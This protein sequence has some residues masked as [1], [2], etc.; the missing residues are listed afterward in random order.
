MNSNRPFLIVVAVL[1]ALGIGYEFSTR[2]TGYE[3]DLRLTKLDQFSVQLDGTLGSDSLGVLRRYIGSHP[4]T[5]NLI[6]G[7][8]PGTIDVD[9]TVSM[10]RWVRKRGL[11][12]S[13]TEDSAIASGAVDLFIG[14]AYRS[15][16]CGATVGVH[17]W[18]YDDGIAASDIKNPNDYRHK[19]QIAFLDDMGLDGQAFYWFTINAAPPERIYL[20]TEEEI[21]QFS[22]S[23][24]YLQ[25]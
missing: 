12:T 8:M 13:I 23:S 20:M 14:G 3:G 4:D 21:N 18:S 25:C 15:I 2:T 5:S 9:A 10:A 11:E 19:A 6:L 17:A 1:I 24:R 22:L 7:D 16:E